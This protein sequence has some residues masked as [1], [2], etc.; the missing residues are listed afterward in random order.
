MSIVQNVLIGRSKNKIGN[1]VFTTWK[2]KNVLK[3]K[4]LTVENPRTDKQLMRRSAMTQIVGMYRQVAGMVSLGWK[5]LAIGKSE[6][7]AFVSFN[8][9]NGFDY[10]TPPT[11]TLIPDQLLLSKGTIAPTSISTVTSSNGSPSV[12]VTWPTSATLPGQAV[13]DKALILCINP[14][15][16]G[17]G[18]SVASIARS[19][20]TATITM[21]ENNATGNE[22]YVYLGFYNETDGKASDSTTFTESV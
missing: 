18:Q 7:N 13:S 11:A 21:S 19:A 6:Y 1:A 3:S 2:G 12:T 14:T 8:L 20:G 17:I 4:P 22:I 10:S 9:L 5:Q 16:D 15:T